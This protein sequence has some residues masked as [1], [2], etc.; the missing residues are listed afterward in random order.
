MKAICF[1]AGPRKTVPAVLVM[2]N[3][4]D[5]PGALGTGEVISRMRLHELALS[6]GAPLQ[7]NIQ[8]CCA[9]TGEGLYE[10]LDW[11]STTL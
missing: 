10:G 4:H 6:V 2:S 5:L 7:W 8:S 1:T 9:I 3:K 11:I